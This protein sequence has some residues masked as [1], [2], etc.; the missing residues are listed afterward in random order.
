MADRY[1]LESGAPDGYLLEDGSGVLLLEVPAEDQPIA[2]YGEPLEEVESGVMDWLEAIPT[3][4]IAAV[5][6]GI[7]ALTLGYA[8]PAPAEELDSYTS[9]VIEEAPPASEE[10][11]VLVLDFGDLE[12][13][14]PPEESVV[15]G[16]FE[17]TAAADPG[18]ILQLVTDLAEDEPAEESV[19][20][21]FFDEVTPPLLVEFPPADDDEPPADAVIA[22]LIEDAASADLTQIPDPVLTDP[23]DADELQDAAIAFLFED[24]VIVELDAALGIDFPDEEEPPQDIEAFIAGV[25]ENAAAPDLTFVPG[26]QDDYLRA[27]EQQR[28]DDEEALLAGLVFD[29]FG[30]VDD[31]PPVIPGVGEYII[32]ARRRHR[33]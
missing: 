32:R 5:S 23:E 29:P 21:Y 28:E 1:L 33:R 30:Q 10:S 14:E 18:A 3:A 4:V 25:F 27:Y 15:V 31:P 13:S 8:E 24:A 16:V 20:P 2:V 11:A 9:Q 26:W 6:A 19:T 17:A 22:Y 7:I 12:E